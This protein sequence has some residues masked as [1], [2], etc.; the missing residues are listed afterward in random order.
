M[1]GPFELSETN[2][3]QNINTG[4]VGAY[5]LSRGNEV[6]HYIGRSDADIKARLMQHLRDGIYKQFW[7]DITSSALEAF[8]L[9]CEWY[10]KYNPPDNKTHP[11]VP[12]G[13]VWKCPVAGCPWSS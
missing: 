6:A 7:F 11:A 10:H 9:E 8:Y 3:S 13:A 2:I 12:P 5:I 1:K 4:K